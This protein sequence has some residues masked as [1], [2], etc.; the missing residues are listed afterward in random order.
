[1]NIAQIKKSF[2][3]KYICVVYEFLLFLYCL[4]TRKKN[5]CFYKEKKTVS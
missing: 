5:C 1:M 3:K 4:N 2:I